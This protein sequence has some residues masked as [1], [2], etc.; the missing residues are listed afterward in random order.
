MN[1]V[2]L[3]TE[4]TTNVPV[5]IPVLFPDRPD[6][7]IVVPTARSCWNEVVNEATV[8]ETKER[9]VIVRVKVGIV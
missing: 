9:F 5:K 2:E 7:V 8:L 3:G 1:V 4:A 6:V